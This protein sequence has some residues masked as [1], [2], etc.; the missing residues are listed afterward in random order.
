MVTDGAALM[1]TVNGFCALTGEDVPAA[2][3][4]EMVK[5]ELP[6]AVGVP[7]ITPLVALIFKP[8]GKVPEA[9]AQVSGAGFPVTARAA[10]YAIPTK[11]LGREGVLIVSASIVNPS[12]VLAVLCVASMS[13]TAIV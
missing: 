8:A 7:L 9:T 11:P 1:T 12:L 4:A 5:V 13:V 6:T 3:V 10:E 2:K